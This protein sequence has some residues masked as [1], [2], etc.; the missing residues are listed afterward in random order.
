M[1]TTRQILASRSRILALLATDLEN[2]Q[3]SE[4]ISN[5][6]RVITDELDGIAEDIGH[7]EPEESVLDDAFFAKLRR[8]PVG[9]FTR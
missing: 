8:S 3:T 7:L 5:G 2:V 1:T 4:A 6:L 9:A